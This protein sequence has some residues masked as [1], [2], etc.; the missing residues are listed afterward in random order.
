MDSVVPPASS[1]APARPAAASAEGHRSLGAL[2]VR[3]EIAAT[4]IELLVLGGPIALLVGGA[5]AASGLARALL[6]LVLALLVASVLRL[7]D[8]TRGLRAVAAARRDNQPVLPATAEQAHVAL[9][10]VP[11]ESG[12]LRLLIWSL[13]LAGAV[14]LLGGHLPRLALVGVFA[15][16]VLIAAALAS[17]RTLWLEWKFAALRPVIFPGR[18]EMAAFMIGYAARLARLAVLYSGL[19]LGSFALLAGATTRIG[20]AALL[21]LG[22]LCWPVLAVAWWAWARSLA[23]RRRAIESYFDVLIRRPGTRGLSRDEATAVP[24]FLAAQSMPYRLALYQGFGVTVSLLGAVASG[25]WVF[26]WDT[27]TVSSL[28]GVVA[29]LAP[30]GILCAVI[31]LR[32]ALRPLLRHLGTRHHL[33]L[34]AIRSPVS[35]RNKLL[36]GLIVVAACG[37]GFVALAWL[38]ARAA[39]ADGSGG[40]AARLLPVL[41]CG[42]LWLGGS[43]L[44]LVRDFARPLR[45]LD[46]RSDEMARGELAR[47]VAPAGEADEV[48]RLTVAFEEMRRALRDR[49]RSTESINV[50]LEREVRRRTEALE[51]RNAELRDALEKLEQAKD[52]LVRSEKLASMGRLVAGIAHEIN[53]PVNAVINS[54]APLEESLRELGAARTGADL[55]ARAAEAETIIGV[56]KRGADRTKTIVRALH[57]YSRS[58]ESVFVAVDLA[59][60]LED[61]LPILQHRLRGVRV[62]SALVDARVRGL[63]GQL[64]QVL[65]NLITNAA[66]AIGD[67]GGLIQVGATTMGDRVIV[68]VKDDGPGI[69]AESLPKIFDPFFTTKAVG[70]GSGLGLSIVHGI[71]ERHGGSITVESPP[72]QGTTFILDLPRAA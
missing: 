8:A 40:L 6:A 61:T 71:I 34:G 25:R 19:V 10:A 72:G 65:M 4:L 60:V 41:A 47:P 28:L 23:R 45:A 50:D 68:R 20:A 1:A 14:G 9:H 56:I 39:T 13:A 11:R 33:P 29:I 27:T 31:G 30:I 54:L 62:E 49:L 63:P 17:A 21:G 2:L 37:G 64:G 15:S 48:G 5:A 44:G 3:F 18:D 70:E 46:D 24:A 22:A 69:P 53:N 7:F 59:R 51:K 42:G 38:A 67:R 36:G 32:S 35:L 57:N 12:G 66:Q 16:G 26:G 43:I 55:A 58:D 52:D